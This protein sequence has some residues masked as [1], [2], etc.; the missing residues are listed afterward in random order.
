MVRPYRC[1]LLILS[2]LLS[3]LAPLQ[4]ASYTF[5]TIDIPS[6]SGTFPF[7]INNR[8]QIVGTYSDD[9]GTHGF[10][11]EGEEFLPLDVPF[12]DALSTQASGIN[13]PGQIVG[14]YRDSSGH[15]GFLYDKGVF[16]TIDVPFPG[17]SSTQASGINERGQ[18][19]GTYSD[20]RGTHG[21]VATP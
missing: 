1:A 15:H 3:S 17:A 6:S 21:F 8:G 14:F 10:L 13:N 2:F 19:V 7:G 16:T 11:E 9:R 18:I 5:T 4:A 12:P 20:D